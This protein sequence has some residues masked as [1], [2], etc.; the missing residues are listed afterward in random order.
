M[1][2]CNLEK[3]DRNSEGD[4]K[5]VEEEGM[6]PKVAEKKGVEKSDM[7]KEAEVRV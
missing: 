2:G 3:K 1:R 4:A 5:S 7:L 6:R